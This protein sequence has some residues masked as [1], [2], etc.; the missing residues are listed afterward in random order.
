MENQRIRLSKT[1]LKNALI[2]LLKTKNIEKITI[3]EL[4]AT[5]QINRTTF[6]KYYGSQY[7]LLADIERELFNELET[8]LLTGGETEYDKLKYV[9][10][11]LDADR[12]K[13]KIL[14]NT[15]ADQDFTE[16]LFSLPTIQA[17]IRSSVPEQYTRRQEEYIRL[18]YCQGGYAII[19]KWLNKEAHETPEEISRLIISL[20]FMGRQQEGHLF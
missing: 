14:I 15:V 2:E 17:L 12:E 19:R 4:C 9:L 13:W 18:F 11:F 7:D 16:K 10:E 8:H 6:Y 3:Y 5:A 20:V 1:M